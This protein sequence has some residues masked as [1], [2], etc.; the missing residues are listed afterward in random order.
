MHASQLPTGFFDNTSML[1]A[2]SF[3]LITLI[4]S[5][6]NPATAAD[7]GYED[8][9]SAPN[10]VPGSSGQVSPALPLNDQVSPIEQW[11]ELFSFV[12]PTPTLTDEQRESVRATLETKLQG[13]RANEV[14]A[15]QKFWPQLKK[16]VIKNPAQENNYQSLLR[17][18]LRME[19]R[20]FMGT[21]GGDQEMLAQILGPVRIAVS[22]EPPLTED[23]IDA[24]SDMACFLFEQKNPGRTMDATDNRTIFAGVI[25][26][27]YKD[28]PTVK[29]KRAMVNFDVDWSKFKILW[30][31][32]NPA[33][34]KVLLQKWTGAP[35]SPGAPAI[36]PNQTLMAV[37]QNGPWSTL[38][39][40]TKSGLDA[41]PQ[42]TNAKPNNVRLTGK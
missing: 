3:I 8:I 17:A 38:L 14:N 24:Y 4:L 22:G 1:L 23:A 6:G 13:P 10:S 26:Q 2:R 9:P 20:T 33:Q 39:H 21:T 11:V 34:R 40:N 36:P 31:D 28:A 19:Y 16:A 27:K 30:T 25:S 15:I 32:A 7:W 12:S 29:D 5:L 18:L 35:A 41:H 42:A 37:L